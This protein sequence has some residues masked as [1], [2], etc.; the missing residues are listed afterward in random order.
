[1]TEK[2]DPRIYHQRVRAPMGGWRNNPA[3]PKGLVYEGV[4]NEPVQLYGETGAQSS[5][6]HAFDA[7]LGISHDEGWLRW[8]QSRRLLVS[9]INVA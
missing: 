5:I 8:V 7:V 2:C 4:S 1:M 9:L 3:L 6:L